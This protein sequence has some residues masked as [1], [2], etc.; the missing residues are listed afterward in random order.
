MIQSNGRK[1]DFK[2]F[3]ESRT[4][5]HEK[6]I[7]QV[8]TGY[9]GL[10]KRHSNTDIPKKRSKKKPLTKEDKKEN[11]RISSS[12]VLVENVIRSL[13]IFRLLAEKYR[14]RRKRYGLRLNLIA[15]IYNFQL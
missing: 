1:H 11:Q 6:T 15:A 9:Q 8:D 13:K 10:A 5:V 12:R 14:N 7:L 2:L 3:K 4:Y